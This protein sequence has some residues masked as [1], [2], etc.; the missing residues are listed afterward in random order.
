M[1]QTIA[2]ASTW[3]VRLSK[4]AV[5]SLRVRYDDARV[6]PCLP[7]EPVY[8]RRRSHSFHVVRV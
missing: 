4:F 1:I 7:S 5:L 8:L 6:Y 2:Q 3:L